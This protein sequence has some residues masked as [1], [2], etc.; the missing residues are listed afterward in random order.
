MPGVGLGF[1]AT[2]TSLLYPAAID[3]QFLL[4]GLDPGYL[5][6]LPGDRSA[7]FYAPSADPAVVSYD[8]AHK[9]V[10]PATDLATLATTWAMPA[11]LN[12]SD[13]IT[14]PVLVVIGAQD[15]IFCTAPPVF[16]CSQPGALLA[17]ER[18]YYSSSSSVSVDVIGDTGHDIALHPSADES[19]A[20][21]SQWIMTH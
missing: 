3:P 11:G 12:V 14:A 6:T 15:A 16:D 5:T 18:P 19:F 20:L 9:D 17:T 21:I 7:D 10:V 1:A 13:S 8:E 2:L 4:H